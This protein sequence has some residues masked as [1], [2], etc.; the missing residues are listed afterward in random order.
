MPVLRPGFRLSQSSKACPNVC[1]IDNQAAKCWLLKVLDRLTR[2][3]GMKPNRNS[4]QLEPIAGN[5]ALSENLALVVPP[6]QLL[7]WTFE[8]VQ[9]FLWSTRTGDGPTPTVPGKT[10][11]RVLLTLLTYS[12]ATGLFSSPEIAQMCRADDTFRYLSPTSRIRASA[13]RKSLQIKPGFLK[14]CTT[15]VGCPQPA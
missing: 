11:Q 13:K 2:D 10:N 15:P 14:V 7:Q 1:V 4:L 9:T 12:Y 3:Q 6:G 8:A 5:F